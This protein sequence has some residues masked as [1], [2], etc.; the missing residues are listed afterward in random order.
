MV[1]IVSAGSGAVDDEVGTGSSSDRVSIHGTVE[2]GRLLT[3]SLSLPVLTS[4]TRRSDLLSIIPNRLNRASFQRFPA[5]GAFGFVLRLF[6]DVGI[7]VLER[8]GEVRRS[9]VC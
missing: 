7:G 6:T 9:R 5:G 8:A 2:F 4:A 3:R 1:D